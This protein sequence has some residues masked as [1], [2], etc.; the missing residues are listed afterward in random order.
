M[1]GG[2][3]SNS[4]LMPAQPSRIRHVCWETGIHASFSVASTKNA[5]HL[6]FNASFHG[7]SQFLAVTW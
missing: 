1:C 5:S 6:F 7:I 2:F 4:T 3:G